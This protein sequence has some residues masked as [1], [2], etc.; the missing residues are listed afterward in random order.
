M[1]WELTPWG[2]EI[3]GE[4]GPLID[5]ETFASLTSGRYA[6]DARVPYMIGACTSSVRKHCGWHIAGSV[7]CR[8]VLDGGASSLWLPAN[9]VLSVTSVDV[10]GAPVTCY[11]WNRQGLL[12]LPRVP[13][14]LRAVVVEYVA[15]HASVPDDLV[16]L[17]KERIDRAL[18]KARGVTQE[19]AGGVSVSYAPSVAVD[20]GG[21]SLSPSDMDAL[22]GYRLV[23]A[24]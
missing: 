23:E 4:L 12:R 2:Y 3:D 18:S 17:V 11:E 10:C 8:A 9:H 6:A 5:A 16:Q 15:G 13:D 21:M 20:L 24:M 1:A 19:T 14:V 7:V 22:S